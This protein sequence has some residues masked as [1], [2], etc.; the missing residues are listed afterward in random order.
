MGFSYL[1]PPIL[2]TKI[3]GTSSVVQWL[4]INLPM[5]GSRVPSLVWEDPTCYGTTKPMQLLK[6]AHLEPEFCNR[7]SHHSE[8]PSITT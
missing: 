7:R 1:M 3:Y 8:K 4:R 5:Q 2:K 6:L